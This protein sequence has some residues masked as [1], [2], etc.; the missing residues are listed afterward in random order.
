[1]HG[2]NAAAASRGRAVRRLQG[3]WTL[4]ESDGV[5][6]GSYFSAPHGRQALMTRMA[7]GRQLTQPHTPRKRWL[8]HQP[9]LMSGARSSLLTRLARFLRC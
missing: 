1:M 7:G 4:H 6:R 9:Q 3:W 2:K 8:A 5:R